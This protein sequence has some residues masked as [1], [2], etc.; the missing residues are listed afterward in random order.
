MKFL[1]QLFRFPFLR[2]ILIAFLAIAILIPIYEKYRAFPPFR[3]LLTNAAEDQAVRIATHLS[4]YDFFKKSSLD[5]PESIPNAWIDEIT[6]ISRDMKLEKVKIFSRSGE[7]I[8]STDQKDMGK[9]NENEYYHNIVTAGQVFTKVVEKDAK[10]L[11]GHVLSKTVVETYVPIIRN[12]S[13]V[14]SFEIYYDI[15]AQRA[16]MNTILDRFNFDMIIIILGLSLLALTLITRAAR[17]MSELETAQEELRRSEQKFRSIVENTL[18]GISITD[19]HGNIQMV[20]QAFSMVTGYKVGEVIDQN[21]RLLHSGHHDKLFYQNMWQT[22]AKTGSW[23]GEVWNR[24]KNG[25]IYP[26]WLSISSIKDVQGK[27]TNYIG[28]FSDITDRKKDEENL[29]HLAF[30]D[31]LTEIPN[32]MLF[33]ERLLHAIKVASRNN[34]SMGVFFLDLDYFKQVNDNHGHEIGDLLLQEVA[35]RL[36]TILRKEDT[37][38][39]LGGDEFSIVLRTVDNPNDTYLVA[40][41]II[42][43]L[44]LP[45]FL[46]E[47]VCKIGTSIGISL[48]PIHAK[49]AEALVKCADEAMYVAKKSGRNCYKLYGENVA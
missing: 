47:H 26:E 40:E 14:G 15:A 21:H 17:A 44:T 33:N 41:K 29:K 25:D 18:E 48:F 9:I 28:V 27:I 23:K 12:N 24:R 46:K 11:D 22:I 35:S 2:N 43:S 7:V 4:S 32:R 49:N 37:V 20:N 34:Q 10:S 16:A 19:T 5:S 39:R 38:A 30:Y 1:E 6:I 13:F 8:Y 45:F 36:L 42:K 31:A 3:D